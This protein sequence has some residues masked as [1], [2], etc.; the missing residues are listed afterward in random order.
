[1]NNLRSLVLAVLC[2]FSVLAAHASI[3]AVSFDD[4]AQEQLYKRMVADLRC[5]VC[6]NQ[7]LADSD[8]ELAIDLRLQVQEMVLKGDTQQDISDYMVARY[9]EFVLYKPPLS[10]RTLVL[11]IGPLMALLLGF[12]IV[13]AVTRRRE[14]PEQ[15]TVSEESIQ[16]ARDLLNQ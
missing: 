15:E 3:D 13:W 10:G 2:L 5:L 1:M 11:W 12:V 14:K 8:A 4:P 6:Q 9:G 16:R 7:N